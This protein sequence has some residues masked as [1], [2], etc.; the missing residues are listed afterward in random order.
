MRQISSS[1]R[2]RRKKPLYLPN[3]SYIKAMVVYKSVY[4]TFFFLIKEEIGN[5][6]IRQNPLFFAQTLD[7]TYCF[8]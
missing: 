8:V 3:S 4:T 2:L 1:Q 6:F 5:N 7:I